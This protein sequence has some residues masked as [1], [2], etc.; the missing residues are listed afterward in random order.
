[1]IEKTGDLREDSIGDDFTPRKVTHVSK[2]GFTAL[3]KKAI[4]E[5]PEIEKSAF[6]KID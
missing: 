1:M 4:D 3:S 6:E 5:K 2:D